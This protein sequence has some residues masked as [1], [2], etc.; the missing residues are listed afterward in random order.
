MGARYPAAVA[1]ALLQSA[2]RQRAGAKAGV[3]S[4]VQDV[5]GR[6]ARSF[7]QWAGEHLAAFGP[8]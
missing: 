4:T 7:R 3:G 8:R 2:E 1:E 6:R 5:V